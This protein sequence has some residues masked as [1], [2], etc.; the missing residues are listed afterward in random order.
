MTLGASDPMTSTTIYMDNH[1][2]TQVDPR[3]VEAMLPF[4]SADYGN[5]GSIGH[6]YGE[7]ASDAVEQ[8]RSSIA[9]CLGA[10]PQEVVFTSGATESNNLAI[11]GVAERP[12]R[13]GNHLVS[14]HSEHHSVLEPLQRL[15]R[16]GYELTLLDVEPHGSEHAGCL[17]PEKVLEVLRNDTML[18]SVMLV[19]NEIGVLQQLY[20]IGKLCRERGVL[21]H[22]DATQAIG[23]IPVDVL[24]ANVDLLSC[25]AHKC[26]GP[27]GVGM[28]YVRCRDP[29]VRLEAQITGGGQQSGRRSGTLNT[30]GIV[31]FSKALELCVAELPTEMARL[32]KLRDRLWNGLNERVSRL[33][34]CGPALS[35]S[36]PY[37]NPL[38]LPSNLNVS[39]GDVD[40]EALLLA[41]GNLAV[42]SGATCA[43]TDP[44]PSHVL[45]ALG[46]GE[47]LAR[48]SLRFGLGRFN[49]EDEVETAIET[50][51]VAV[52]QLRS[53]AG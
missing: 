33:Q 15:A 10:E 43:S 48:S 7:T 23:K 11:R 22:C 39:F 24:E 36:D 25:S 2:T 27:K 9:H 30:P 20:E 44:G 50:V 14:V 51:V 38:R 46:M 3:V 52:E 53:K 37:G 17:D 29:V 8:A 28:L 40:G 16:R 35:A 18:V 26:Y 47:D 1:A 21:V 31:G 4:F 34:L 32:A 5:P 41:M 6:C 45:L 19:N 13:R 12:R 42:S 49:T